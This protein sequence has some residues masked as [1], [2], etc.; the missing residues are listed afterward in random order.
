MHDDHGVFSN[1][2]TSVFLLSRAQT[3]RQHFFLEKLERRRVLKT[4]FLVPQEGKAEGIGWNFYLQKF[5]R[6]E[7]EK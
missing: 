7:I 6:E 2:K 5:Q 3:I 1:F 4:D